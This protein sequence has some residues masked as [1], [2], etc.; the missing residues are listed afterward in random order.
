M[1][2]YSQLNLLEYSIDDIIHIGVE[3]MLKREVDIEKKI[4]YKIET[5]NDNVI[6]CTCKGFKYNNKCKHI[7]IINKMINIRL[8]RRQLGISLALK[9][10]NEKNLQNIY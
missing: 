7:N 6:K 10:F 1:C 5:K 2:N 3:L 4:I 8:N 9:Y